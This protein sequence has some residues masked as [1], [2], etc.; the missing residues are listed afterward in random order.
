MSRRMTASGDK[1][2]V[3]Q[4]NSISG[5]SNF[6]WACW[7]NPNGSFVVSSPGVLAKLNGAGVEKKRFR[8]TH[9]Q[10]GRRFIGEVMRGAAMAAATSASSVITLGEWQHLAMTYTE[11]DGVRLYRDGDEVGYTTRTVGS[12]ATEPDADGAFVIGGTSITL[13]GQ[14]AEVGIWGR[15][16]TGAELRVLSSGR[17]S[18]VLIRQGLLAA[19]RLLGE[20]TPEPDALGGPAA[21]PTRTAAGEHPPGVIAVLPERSTALGELRGCCRQMG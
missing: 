14:V 19:W 18:P 7:L 21:V 4:P 16:L 3:N 10:A 15:V 5:L 13:D 1:L 17:R 12:G 2:Q 9:A 6:T 20:M 11:A 8:I